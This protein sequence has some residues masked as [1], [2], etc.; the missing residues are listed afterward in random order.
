MNSNNNPETYN[1]RPHQ[2]TELKEAQ[3][4][5]IHQDDHTETES[6]SEILLGN[7]ELPIADYREQILDAVNHAQAT[8][9]TAETGAGKSTQVPQFLAQEGYHVIVTQPRILAA[10]SL[11]ERVTEEIVDKTSP[12]FEKF[13]GYRTSKERHDHP[14]NQILFVTDG[15]QMIRELTAN[16]NRDTKQVLV[17]DEVHEWNLN[18][19]VLLAWSKQQMLENDNFK[20]VCMSATM[21]ADSLAR[22]LSKDHQASPTPIINV[23][24]RTF[25]VEKYQGGNV[26]DVT[27]QYVQQGK[28]TLVFAPG[29]E[30]IAK[31]ITDL[32]QRQLDNV[33]ILPLHGQLDSTNQR[34]VFKHYPDKVK[35]VVATNVAQTSITID[36][37]HAVVDTGLE[38]SAVFRNGVDS[39]VLQNISQADC[40]QRAGRAG[41]VGPGQY[42]L[43]ALE[44]ETPKTLEERSSYPVPEIKRSRLDKVIL[45]IA[46]AGLDI[47]QLDFY[48]NPDPEEVTKSKR[49]LRLLGA[50]D[51]E[52]K[53][54]KIGQQMERLPVESH[55]ARMMVEAKRFS[56]EIQQQM[57]GVIAVLEAGDICM[58]ETPS[59]KRE[60][61]WRSLLN[62]E[63][64]NS[65]PVMRYD[66]LLKTEK[67][68]IK[69]LKEYD[70]HL[71]TLQNARDTLR[72]LRKAAR[73][74]NDKLTAPNPTQFQ[75]LIECIIPGMIESVHPT[76][77]HPEPDISRRGIVRYIKDGSLYVCNQF[78]IETKQGRNLTLAQNITQFSADTLL[79]VL[80]EMTDLGTGIGNQQY[81]CDEEGN[82]TD[83]FN[84]H[85]NGERLYANKR[86]PI[87]EPLDWNG[88]G[89]KIYERIRELFQNIPVIQELLPYWER[90]QSFLPYAY[91]D[92]AESIK[93][94]MI[95]QLP[96][97]I[98]NIH[99]LM[100]IANNWTIDDFLSQEYRDTFEANFPRENNSFIIH[101]DKE[102]RPTL[103][104][105]HHFNRA[106][107]TIDVVCGKDN[108]GNAIYKTVHIT[109]VPYQDLF[110]PNG[111]PLVDQSYIKLYERYKQASQRLTCMI[112]SFE[113]RD[114]YDDPGEE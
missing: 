2:L 65:E 75:E 49:R 89:Y 95:D 76:A 3:V 44:G 30:E 113:A 90:D 72:Q 53:L 11:S 42:T 112:E 1:Y 31:I 19:E 50:L 22:F 97:K 47:E 111:K 27:Q 18:M 46:K 77:G 91:G 40:L 48:H 37:I 29:K 52:D 58:H 101:Y 54:T 56:P 61:K 68:S 96:Q 105:E 35:V 57:A 86:A 104:D 100:P 70:F 88:R 39:L 41:R 82:I 8:I 92:L 66:L 6:T 80:P 7:T 107:E 74:S 103:P 63:Y 55:Y 14:D 106:T 25:P 28:N 9:I 85:L 78:M 79:K 51:N 15:L 69:Q 45:H 24:G 87:K 94:Q 99:Q 84:I 102:A 26:I 83:N 108:Q 32:N 21:E 16:T 10:R 98:T 81:E 20:V 33:I 23:P 93:R 73:L 38:R 110:L 114:I 4:H 109:E 62:V 59:M 5:E 43:A 36:D 71:K 60:E 34:K 13:V 67:M 12:A 17:L 64:H